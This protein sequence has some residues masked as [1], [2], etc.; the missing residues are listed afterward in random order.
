MT[1]NRLMLSL[2]VLAAAAFGGCVGYIR[3][4][5]PPPRYAAVGPPPAPGLV[6]APG[7]WGW[8]GAAY[9]WAPGRWIAPPY[10]GAVW[11]PAH[12]ARRRRGWFFVRGHWR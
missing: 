12:W 7:Y 1:I 10:R 4:A 3:P 9:V 6:W 5:P 2:A 8:N 11:V